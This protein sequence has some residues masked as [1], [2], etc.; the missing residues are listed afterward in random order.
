MFPVFF[1]PF[2]M[3]HCE[4]VSCF[5]NCC[6]LGLGSGNN[7]SLDNYFPLPS[8]QSLNPFLI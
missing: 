5:E 2:S 4:P 1:L 7:L 6:K 3:K 8:L